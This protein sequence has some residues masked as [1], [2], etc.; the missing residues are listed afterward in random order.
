MILINVD[1]LYSKYRSFKSKTEIIY[2]RYK[3][4]LSLDNLGIY[5]TTINDPVG[6]KIEQA[7]KYEQFIKTVEVDRISSIGNYAFMD[8]VNVE[9]ITIAN[10]VQTIG[11]NPFINCEILTD[12]TFDEESKFVF[13]NRM[14]TYTNEQNKKEL[15][16]YL[17]T[18]TD[19]NVIIDDISTIKENAIYSNQYLE[20]LIMNTQVKSIENKAIYNCEKLQYLYHLG[21]ETSITGIPVIDCSISRIYVPIE[22]SSNWPILDVVEAKGKYGDKIIDSH[23]FL[24]F[25]S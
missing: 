10:S 22:Y 24:S 23:I 4:C 16:S 13:Q 21:N 19:K 17:Q 8:C 11:I 12:V 7:D 9:N 3:S 1:K 18:K 20:V 6:N 5:S 25:P 14:I 15:I 2:K